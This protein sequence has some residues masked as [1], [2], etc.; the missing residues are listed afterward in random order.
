MLEF[1][2]LHGRKDGDS[3]EQVEAG[4]D[5]K[6][7][8]LPTNGR[9]LLRFTGF[10]FGRQTLTAEQYICF[11]FLRVQGSESDVS[12]RIRRS[13]YRWTRRVHA[14]S[15]AST[16]ACTAGSSSPLAEWT[17]TRTASARVSRWRG[18]AC[19]RRSCS[20]ACTRS[21]SCSSCIW[22]RS[23][24][25]PGS[26]RAGLCRRTCDDALAPSSPL[27]PERDPYLKDLA[28]AQHRAVGSGV[29]HYRAQVFFHRAATSRDHDAMTQGQHWFNPY[30]QHAGLVAEAQ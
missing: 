15:N 10:R 17:R 2:L 14:R 16:A 18:P 23:R 28:P 12:S 19:S 26:L 5:S 8:E 25:G 3:G 21:P 6:I 27:P 29:S 20:T 30:L 11:A 7:R 1:D 22:R 24:W 4:V 9:T 13:R